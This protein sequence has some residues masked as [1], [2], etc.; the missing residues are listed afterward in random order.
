MHRQ[1]AAHVKGAEKTDIAGGWMDQGELSPMSQ[2]EFAQMG[3][4]WAEF[5]AQA[6]ENAAADLAQLKPNYT[7]NRKKIIEFAEVRSERPI[8]ATAVLAA[9]F[10]AL[11]EETLGP[12]ILVVVPN[13][14]T[15]FVFPKL[16]S[17]YRDYSDMVYRAYRETSHPVSL[18][19]FELSE[20]GIESVGRFADPAHD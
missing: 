8:V 2:A 10:R 13:Q 1:V 20:K 3:V 11:F 5:S 18:E 4:T 17:S 7:R 15:A 19:L 14:Q 12:S 16:A 6:V 9:G